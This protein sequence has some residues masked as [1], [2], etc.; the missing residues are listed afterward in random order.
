MVLNNKFAREA[1]K[2]AATQVNQGVR[3]GARQFVERE[4]EPMRARVDELE[5]RVARLERQL[6]EL[7]RERERQRP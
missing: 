3:D 7:M 2:Q 1:L 4:I 6:A 5:G